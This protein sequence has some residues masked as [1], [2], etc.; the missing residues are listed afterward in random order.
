MQHTS[1]C[2]FSVILYEGFNKILYDDFDDLLSSRAEG[3]V[4]SINTYWHARKI[5]NPDIGSFA[6]AARNWVEEMRKDPELMNV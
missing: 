1:L 6:M 2:A 5:E 3:V 4:N